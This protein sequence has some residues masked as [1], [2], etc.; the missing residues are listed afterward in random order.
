MVS[1]VAGR[2]MG[3]GNSVLT[4]AVIGGVLLVCALVTLLATPERPAADPP[5]SAAD[6][7][8][9]RDLLRVNLRRYPGY[10]RLIASSL[11]GS[12]FSGSSRE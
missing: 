12:S 7:K 11:V 2:L 6:Y 8:F 3:D 9:L 1:L 5:E 10:T 4:F